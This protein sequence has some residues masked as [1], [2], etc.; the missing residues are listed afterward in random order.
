[1]KNPEIKILIKGHTDN[2]GDPQLN[3]ELSQE[4]SNVVMDYIVTKGIK[5]TRLQ[6]K[7]YGGNQPIAP[8]DTEENRRLNRRVEDALILSVCLPTQ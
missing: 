8:N 6:W 2:V 1:M 3:L 4:R 5:F 7:G